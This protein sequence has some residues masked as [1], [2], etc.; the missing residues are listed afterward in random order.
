MQLSA[1]TAKS[2]F[3]PPLSATDTDEIASV[4]AYGPLLLLVMAIGTALPLVPESCAPKFTLGGVET[5]ACVAV[6]DR[7]TVGGVAPATLSVADRAPGGNVAEG[8]NVTVIGQLFCAGM[9]V[10]EAAADAEKS[11]AFAPDTL[12]TPIP[13]AAPPLL[14]T[15]TICEA[16]VVPMPCGPNARLA[17]DTESE[18][19][20]VA[21]PLRETCCGFPAALSV[22][23]RLAFF[24]PAVCGAN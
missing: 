3:S 12:T 10:H 16:L 21:L 1:A 6:P 4:P 5:A 23:L 9:L 14:E 24:E 19:A 15:V 13:A 17:G 8:M 2:P 11:V 22:K 20:G 18:G 7:A